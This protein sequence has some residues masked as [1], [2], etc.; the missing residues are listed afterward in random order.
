MA[1]DHPTNK[2]LWV[3]RDSRN[4]EL[5]MLVR[6]LYPVPPEHVLNAVYEAL[7]PDRKLLRR[8]VGSFDRNKGFTRTEWETWFAFDLAPAIEIYTDN[9]VYHYRTPLT[10]WEWKRITE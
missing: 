6:S 4:N 3:M 9:F 8:L 5:V 1:Y 10:K 2:H 7:Y